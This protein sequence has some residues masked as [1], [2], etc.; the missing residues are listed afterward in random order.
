M[1]RKITA[2]LLAMAL[3]VSTA[4]CGGG[5]SSSSAAPE[6]SN[7]AESSNAA[8]ESAASETG[9][10]SGAVGE[11]AADS[12]LTYDGEEVTITYWHTHSDQEAEVLTEQI[13]PEFEKQFPKIHVD[14]VVMP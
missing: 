13:I 10:E 9:E 5:G 11:N 7:P 1:K 3:L 8:E 12:T 2:A 14:S 4:A 6:S